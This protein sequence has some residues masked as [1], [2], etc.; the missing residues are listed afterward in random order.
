VDGKVTTSDLADLIKDGADLQTTVFDFGEAVI[1]RTTKGDLSI[2]TISGIYTR[3]IG[4]EME[5]LCLQCRGNVGI[6]FKDIKIN[7]IL[8][9]KFDSSIVGALKNIRDRYQSKNQLLL[10]CMPPRELV[11]LLKLTGVYSGYQIVE[12]PS[13]LVFDTG[14]ASKLIQ[15]A[16]VSEEKTSYSEHKT[17]VLQKRILNLNQSLKRTVSLEKGLDSAEKCIKRFLPQSPPIAEGYNFAFSYNSSEKVGGDFFDFILLGDDAIGILIGDVSGHGIDAALLMGISKKVIHLRAKQIGNGSPKQVLCHANA[18][19]VGDF[20]KYAFVTALYGIL[21]LKTGSFTFARAG[22]E[23]PILFGPGQFKT[24]L[25]SKGIPLATD[26]GKHFDRILEEKTVTI[27]KGVSLFLCTDGIAECWNNR[28][29]QYT[30]ERLVFTLAQSKRN[31]ACREVLDGVL[32]SVNDFASGS[33]QEDDMT[34]IL[35]RRL[36]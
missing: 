18:D 32:Q 6:E 8:H 33:P 13:S 9:K 22:H 25:Q 28:G 21:N 24:I 26:A 27:E 10:L 7:P 15:P 2:F 3:A 20:H 29:L 34:A 19:L 30:R 11:D 5:R 36:D 16:Y 4:K 23:M 1:Q 17:A 14:F 12:K 35:L 31:L